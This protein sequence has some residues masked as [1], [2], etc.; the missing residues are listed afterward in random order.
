MPN[1]CFS[2]ISITGDKK[3]LS[4]LKDNLE[5]AKIHKGTENSFGEGWLGNIVEYLGYDYNSIPCRGSITD[6]NYLDNEIILT[7]ETA[8]GPIMKPI[9]MLVDKF[10]PNSQTLYF[11][12]EPGCCIF[13]TNDPDIVGKYRLDV[14]D[15]RIDID[16][17]VYEP[18]SQD[19]LKDWL[20]ELLHK[21]D[22]FNRLLKEASKEYDFSINK[23]E[24][25]DINDL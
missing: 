12:E 7:T 3:E 5:K 17:W 4:I 16:D 18:Q 6:Y 24:Y 20:E 8:W 14:W 2:E 9:L 25:C 23:Y 13:C 19:D 22:G 11:S 21:K 15:D 10:A 1:W